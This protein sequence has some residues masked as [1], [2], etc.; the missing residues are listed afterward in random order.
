MNM[1]DP[2]EK[3]RKLV[4]RHASKLAE[5]LYS[6]FPELRDEMGR[7][8]QKYGTPTLS[9]GQGGLHSY[10]VATRVNELFSSVGS[11]N[12]L[13]IR[14]TPSDPE[15]THY[16]LEWYVLTDYDGQLRRAIDVERGAQA[17]GDGHQDSASVV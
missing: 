9:G 15:A 14:I 17:N 1:I 5:A 11:Y 7:N 8:I 16:D 12:P 10:S 13:E 4:D 3:A 6:Q 2:M